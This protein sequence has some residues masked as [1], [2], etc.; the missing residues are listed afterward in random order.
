MFRKK[1]IIG[2]STALSIILFIHFAITFIYLSPDNSFRTKHWNVMNEYMSPFFTQNWN[3]FAPNPVNRHESLQVRLRYTDA[4]GYTKTSPWL[5]V[6]KPII[7]DLQKFPFYHLSPS[8]R[9]SEY[10]GA[11]VHD[12]VWKKNKQQQ[13]AL[14]SLKSF[15][16]QMLQRYPENFKVN[17]KIDHYQLRVEVNEFP[18][19]DKR[20]QPDSKG[21]FWY[22]ETIWLPYKG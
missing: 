15:T 20:N 14:H 6:S 2:L 3:L 8:A 18:R 16:N 17:G 12:Y 1:F 7:Q 10:L 13:A 11:G 9:L 5:E 21:E 19:F 4:N 22:R